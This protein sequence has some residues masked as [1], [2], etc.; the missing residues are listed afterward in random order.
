MY[1]DP[2]IRLLGLW[3][4]EINTASVVLRLFLA[5]VSSAIIGFE[6]TNKRHA[7]GLRTF[8]LVTMTGT[9]AM[10][11]DKSF[12]VNVDLPIISAA[13]LI[14]GAIIATNSVLFSSRSQIKGL[15]TSVALWACGVMGMCFGAGQYSMALITCL[16]LYL[17]LH[18]LPSWEKYLKDRSNHFE[19]HLELKSK[20]NLQ[21]FVSTI[22]RLGLI[23]DDIE[24]NPAYVNSG[25]SV[26]TVSISISSQELK[27]YKTHK[28]IIEAL[29]TLDYVYYIGEI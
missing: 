19:V 20:Y 21:D 13:T 17:L 10:L 2:V 28:E 11:L 16:A 5:V 3:A 9:L 24:S 6:R 8:I 22:R 29:S 26:Y 1:L 7:A 25:L 23:I 4:R 18:I 12:M 15:T 14:G 27:K